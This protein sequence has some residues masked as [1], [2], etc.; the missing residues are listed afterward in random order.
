MPIEIYLQRKVGLWRRA[1]EPIQQGAAFCI[2][3][4]SSPVTVPS[5][6]E[7]PRMLKTLL[8]G[9]PLRLALAR[10]FAQK[11]LETWAQIAIYTG[12][13]RLSAYSSAAAAEILLTMLK[14]EGHFDGCC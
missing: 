4:P 3:T 9:L 10:C 2:W 6:T 12:S 13:K 14:P 1:I 5:G 8:G 7:R 11:T